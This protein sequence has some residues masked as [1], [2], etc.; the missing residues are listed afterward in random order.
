M[1]M[2][3]RPYRY[4]ATLSWGGDTPT[5]EVEVECSYSVVWGA[6]PTRLYGPPENY[7]PGSPDEIEDISILTVDGKP[8][9]VDL[10]HGFQ[11]GAQDHEMLTEKLFRDHEEAMIEEARAMEASRAPDDD[12]YR[13]RQKD[14]LR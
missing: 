12:D 13:S 8:W 4:A 7:D 9:P 10:T 2:T 5:A 14:E 3:R 1:S 6:P 11:S